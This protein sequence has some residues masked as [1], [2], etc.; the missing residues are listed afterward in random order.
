M[1]A[2]SNKCKAKTQVDIKTRQEENYQNENYVQS[3]SLYLCRY[4]LYLKLESSSQQVFNVY[5]MLSD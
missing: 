1:I 4:A 2:L 3:Q 5:I